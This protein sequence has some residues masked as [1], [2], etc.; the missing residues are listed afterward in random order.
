MSADGRMLGEYPLPTPAAGPRAIC[1]AGPGR[2]LFSEYDNGAIGEI[3]ILEPAG[4]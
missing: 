1:A 3:E 2:L 4:A